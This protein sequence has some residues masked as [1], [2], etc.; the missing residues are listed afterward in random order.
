MAGWPRAVLSECDARLARR[1]GR[2]GDGNMGAT[3]AFLRL[4]ERHGMPDTLRSAVGMIRGIV[5]ERQTGHVD[6]REF[7]RLSGVAARNVAQSRRA[8]RIGSV[9][10]LTE[11]G[12]VVPLLPV[13]GAQASRRLKAEGLMAERAAA[14]LGCTYRGIEELIET[15][16][17]VRSERA[18]DD[19]STDR[20]RIEA[21][22]LDALLSA[23]EEAAGPASGD[24]LVLP[25]RRALS[26]IGGR[27]K[28]WSAVFNELLSGAL[29][30]ALATGDRPLVDRVLIGREDVDAVRLLPSRFDDLDSRF[31]RHMTK[32]DAHSVLNVEGRY[33]GGLLDDWVTSTGPDRTVPVKEVLQ[34]AGRLVSSREIAARTGRSAHGMR[35]IIDRPAERRRPGGLLDRAATL[36]RAEDRCDQSDR[37]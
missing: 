4:A 9:L 23:V 8:G 26:S 10:G 1:V 6:T 21:A 18:V 33:A 12:E 16:L 2:H 19:C 34:L 24:D 31:D 17:L 22:S 15:G 32:K 30:F 37:R 3:A 5:A 28:P 13:E 36:E 14:R 25:L 29:P 27:L 7:A 20:L 35:R 11:A